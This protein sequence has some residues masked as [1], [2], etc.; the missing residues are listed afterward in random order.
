MQV[1]AKWILAGLGALSLSSS[2]RAREEG[3]PS[4]EPS[5]AMLAEWTFDAT[6]LKT[7]P[8]GFE[9]EHGRWRVHEEPSAPSG[10][11]A[12]AQEGASSSPEFNLVL[13][14]RPRPRDLALSVRMRAVS[15]EIDQGG[16]LVWRAR[17]ARNYYVVRYNPLESNYRVYEVVDG[18]RR[19]L[20]SA[21]IELDPNAWHELSVVA[22]GARIECSLDGTPLL[23][24]EDD[25]FAGA[26]RIGL[27]TKADARTLFDDLRV[28]AR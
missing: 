2:C 8:P 25:T 14:D 1:S 13:A 6:E 26:G 16:G 15:G 27:W 12:L 17:D 11:R 5:G 10:A 18:D 3:A 23:E 4:T 20:E 22:R 21:D 28:E 19:M 24:V 9:E 7:L